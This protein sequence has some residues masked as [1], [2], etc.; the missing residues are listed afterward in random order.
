[1]KK[2]ID[3]H[4]GKRFIW[5]SFSVVASPVLLVKKP[6]KSLWFCVDYCALNAITMKNRYPIPLIFE[7]LEKLIN[8][9]YFTKL[10]VMHVFNWIQIKKVKNKWLFSTLDMVNLNIS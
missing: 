7:M 5:L 6:R 8:V 3:K 4:L 1:M 2:Y 9:T 10:D